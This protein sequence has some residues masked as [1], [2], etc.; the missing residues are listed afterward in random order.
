[1]EKLQAKHILLFLGRKRQGL[2]TLSSLS[3][4]ATHNLLAVAAYAA[5]PHGGRHLPQRNAHLLELWG[6]VGPDVEAMCH[7]DCR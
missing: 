3:V 5:E 2:Q 7:P 6:R 1:M 4:A